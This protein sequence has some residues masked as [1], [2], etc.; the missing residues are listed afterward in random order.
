MKKDRY[1]FRGKTTDTGKWVTGSL[2]YNEFAHGESYHI[3]PF[4]ETKD[5]PTQIYTVT[6]ASVGQC[7]GLK[8]K[9]G[10]LVFEGDVLRGCGM[11][12]MGKLFI[13]S[14]EDY[15]ASFV[16]MWNDDKKRFHINED[17]TKF[18]EVIS[19]IYDNPELLESEV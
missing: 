5:S 15:S 18:F 1:L 19:N 12:N 16:N 11:N 7:T 6:K 17:T 4:L 3:V 9:D 2:I 14:F 13:I 10:T 8:A